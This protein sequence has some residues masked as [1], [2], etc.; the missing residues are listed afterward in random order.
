MPKATEMRTRVAG[1]CRT[2]S[3]RRVG[4]ARGVSLIIVLLILVVVTTVGIGGAQIALMGERSARNDRDYQLAWQAAEAALMDAEYDIRGPNPA[5]AARVDTFRPTNLLDFPPSCGNASAGVRRGLCAPAESGK[6]VWLTVNLEADAAT[7]FATSIGTRTGRTFAVGSGNDA[8]PA[9]EPRYVIEAIA[10]P[11]VFGNKSI[12]NPTKKL[13][14]RV[15]S[16]GFGPRTD[17]QAVVQML[18]R[19]E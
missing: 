15:T 8:R 5:A 11:E 17:I 7:T 10:D 18:Y 19:K 6:P 13:V 14:Y 4:H 2:V 1:Y 9:R 16:M 3:V 12:N